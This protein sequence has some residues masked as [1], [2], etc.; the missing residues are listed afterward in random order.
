MAKDP[1]TRER[2]AV[3]AM[4]AAIGALKAKRTEGD[5]ID[6]VI[7]KL[8]HAVSK[9]DVRCDHDWEG[10]QSPHGGVQAT[11]KKCGVTRYS[12]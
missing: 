9:F 4:N 2:F 8:E 3:D 11:C 1:V 5:R 12:Q 10:F 6:E 7:A